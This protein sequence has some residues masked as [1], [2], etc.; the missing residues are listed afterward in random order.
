QAVLGVLERAIGRSRGMYG[1]GAYVHQYQKFGA[2]REDFEE[3]F[4]GVGQAVEN[5]RSLG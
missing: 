4:L 5:Y 2:E 1:A 3:A